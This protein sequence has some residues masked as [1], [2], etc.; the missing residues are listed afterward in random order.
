MNF[1][2]TL[3]SIEQ[4]LAH[5]SLKAESVSS[6]SIGWHLHHLSLTNVGVLYSL[7]KNEPG[8][9][10]EE[11]NRIRENVFGRGTIRRGVVQAPDA[12]N[13]EDVPQEERIKALLE[14]QRALFSTIDTLP[15]SAYFQHPFM[16]PLDK[17][18]S[19]EFM[20]IHNKHHLSIVEEVLA[21]HR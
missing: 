19:I 8:N 6:K 15:A 16:G 9:F 18:A 14:K 1:S 7:H 5:A 10:T 20:V 11:K 12:V 13:P 3:D 2:K 4:L 21:A 17:K